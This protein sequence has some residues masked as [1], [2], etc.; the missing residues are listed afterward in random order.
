[1][2]VFQ[3]SSELDTVLH[4]LKASG[5]ANPVLGMNQSH[6]KKLDW[7]ISRNELASFEEARL[8]NAPA[9]LVKPR[10]EGSKRL[11]FVQSHTDDTK[12]PLYTLEL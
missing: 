9:V 7:E 10:R 11:H 4:W 6:L 1:V 5:M 12:K 8:G 2:K 3:N